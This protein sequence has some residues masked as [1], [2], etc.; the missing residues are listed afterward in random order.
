VDLEGKA[1]LGADSD[2]LDS[3][4]RKL[5]ADGARTLLL[6]LADLTQ[7]DSAGIGTIAAACVSLTRQGGALKLLRPRGRVRTALDALKWSDY[8]ATFE[9]EAQALASFRSDAQ[10]AGA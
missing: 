3:S 8:I 5:I 6:N 1:T 4:L 10:S 9:D 2:T 7:V